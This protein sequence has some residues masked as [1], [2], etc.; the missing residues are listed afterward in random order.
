LHLTR[1]SK[2]TGNAITAKPEH[3]AQDRHESV[4]V[5]SV[6]EEVA[7]PST[8]QDSHEYGVRPRHHFLS[9]RPSHRKCFDGSYSLFATFMLCR[10]GRGLYIARFTRSSLGRISLFSMATST[11]LMCR[12]S[13][14]HPFKSAYPCIASSNPIMNR[15]QPKNI[16]GLNAI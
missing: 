6:E 8:A 5:K 10:I 1:A 11:A 15:M 9:V 16:S 12:H 3:R 7:E 2:Q 14:S 4:A 13:R